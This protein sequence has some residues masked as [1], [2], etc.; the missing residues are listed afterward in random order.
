MARSR[1]PA[2]GRRDT[3]PVGRG[4]LPGL[5]PSTSLRSLTVPLPRRVGPAPASGRPGPPLPATGVGPWRPE[6]ALPGPRRTAGGDRTWCPRPTH[7]TGVRVGWRTRRE[8]EES[9]WPKPPRDPT[10]P[11]GETRSRRSA[12]ALS[13]GPSV[14]RSP[15]GRRGSRAA[16]SAPGATKRELPPPA[17]RPRADRRVLLG[18]AVGARV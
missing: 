14:G 11:G 15:P 17:T 9:R 18:Y 3:R 10:P 13:G 12:P 16:A 7:R 8:T 4:R 5:P 2:A 6:R 1:S